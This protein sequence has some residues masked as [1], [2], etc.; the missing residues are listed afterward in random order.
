MVLETLDPLWRADIAVFTNFHLP[1]RF[2]K[3][4]ACH[5]GKLVRKPA[6]LTS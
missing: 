2:D 3:T 1:S 4:A 6:R 5:D